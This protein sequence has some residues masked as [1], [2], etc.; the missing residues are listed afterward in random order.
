MLLGRSRAGQ[1]VNASRRQ[2]GRS[3]QTPIKIPFTGVKLRYAQRLS[4]R[5]GSYDFSLAEFLGHHFILAK[6]PGVALRTIV[7]GCRTSLYDRER[8]VELVNRQLP[9][10][11]ISFATP[12]GRSIYGVTIQPSLPALSEQERLRR[13]LRNLSKLG[14]QRVTVES[15]NPQDGG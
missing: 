14:I 9:H 8:L 7:I 5:R 10:V 11:T 12:A 3:S 4:D 15:G 1:S 6:F 2:A 13:D